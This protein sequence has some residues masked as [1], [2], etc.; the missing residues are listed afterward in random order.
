MA[1]V[2][3]RG[4]DHL[5]A[6]PLVPIPAPVDFRDA[7]RIILPRLV[8]VDFGSGAG[9]AVALHIGRQKLNG[10][11]VESEKQPATPLIRVGE[12]HVL[13]RSR[14]LDQ[15]LELRV[16]QGP[17]VDLGLAV[18]ERPA[19]LDRDVAK[20]AKLTAPRLALA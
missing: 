7:T 9:I 18:P 3:R 16:R 2:R 11:S 12:G 20:E 19:R 4:H 1:S 15:R 14:L 10:A 13:H 6:V 5:P 17:G 8:E